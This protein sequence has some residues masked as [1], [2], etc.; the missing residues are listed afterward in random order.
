MELFIFIFV[1]IYFNL[2]SQFH[3]ILINT[4]MHKSKKGKEL[5]KTM[6]ANCI[7]AF[8]QSYIYTYISSHFIQLQSVHFIQFNTIVYYV[9]WNFLLASG[10]LCYIR[11]YLPNTW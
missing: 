2:F 8:L 10:M 6:I 1:S 4:R 5:Q 3:F 11:L 9:K 7:W